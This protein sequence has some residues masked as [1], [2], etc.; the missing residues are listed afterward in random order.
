M[1]VRLVPELYLKQ[2]GR[3][4]QELTKYNLWKTPLLSST[5]FTWSTLEYL[6]PYLDEHVLLVVK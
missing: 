5:N 6:D 3:S 2:M 4:I 1:L